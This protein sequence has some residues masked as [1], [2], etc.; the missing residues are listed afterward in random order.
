MS[1]FAS[2]LTAFSSIKPQPAGSNVA[3]C[4]QCQTVA[5]KYT[6]PGCAFK[7]CSLACSK[8]HKESSSCSGVRNPAT[9]IPPNKYS[10]SSLVSDYTFLSSVGRKTDEVARDQAASALSEEAGKNSKRRMD[11]LKREL[12]KVGLGG[13]KFLPEGMEGRLANKTRWDP[14]TQTIQ[15]TISFN[16]RSNSLP[17]TLLHSIPLQPQTTL[18]SLLPSSP[19]SQTSPSASSST[20]VPESKPS[21]ELTSTSS[22]SPPPLLSLST[23]PL[24]LLPHPFNNPTQP[25]YY[26]P[27]SPT[28]PILSVLQHKSF[29]EWPRIE[30]WDPSEWSRALEGETVRVVLPLSGETG[31]QGE[32]LEADPRRESGDGGRTGKRPRFDDQVDS[33][34]GARAG[35][36]ATA[37]AISTDEDKTTD[38]LPDK[39]QTDKTMP[40]AVMH[41]LVRDGLGLLGDYGSDDSDNEVDQSV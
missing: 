25:Q 10:Y 41:A 13:I 14:K 17:P 8:I 35:T 21:S 31:A 38:I 27:L 33:G 30:L 32:Q 36:R 9:F 39:E 7:T 23:T 34:W 37:A 28:E 12:N 11:M 5:S 24:F 40:P 2:D 22:L 16:D 6:C 15:L 29:I 20:T 19:S 1:S 18:L 26:P 3:L 4:A